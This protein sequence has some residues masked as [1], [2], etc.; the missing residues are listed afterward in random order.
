MAFLS[1]KGELAPG[2]GSSFM[3]SEACRLSYVPTDMTAW[4]LCSHVLPSTCA[5]VPGGDTVDYK[6][7]KG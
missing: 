4:L 1:M 6:A 5:L 7:G 3:F 2:H